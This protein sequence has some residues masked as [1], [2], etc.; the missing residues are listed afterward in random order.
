M[1]LWVLILTLFGAMVAAFGRNLPPSLKATVLLC[2]HDR[3][4]V[5]A[6]H[7]ANVQPVRAPSPRR[8][9]AAT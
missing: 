2:R 3:N 9:R 8:S 1:L 5:P 7:P 6:V 4:G